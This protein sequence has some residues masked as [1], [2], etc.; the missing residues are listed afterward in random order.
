VKP[1]RGWGMKQAPEAVVGESRRGRAKRRGRT[2]GRGW[3][4]ARVWIATAH[5]AMGKET[6]REALTA[7]VQGAGSMRFVL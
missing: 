6:P 2:E 7:S 4:L 1:G 3:D 5:A